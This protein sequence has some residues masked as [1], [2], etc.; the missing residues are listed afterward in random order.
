MSASDKLDIAILPSGAKHAAIV[1]ARC[2]CDMAIAMLPATQELKTLLAF[3]ERINTVLLLNQTRPTKVELTAFGRALFDYIVRD[4]VRRLYDRLPVDTLTRFQILVM[5]PELQALP[6]EYLQDPKHAPGPWTNRS[7]I[8]VIPMIGHTPPP[9]LQLTQLAATGSK[10]RILFVY[11]VP[12]DQDLVSWPSV[13]AKM[14]E[15]FSRRIPTEHYELKTIRGTTEELFAALEDN[16]ARYDI[17]Q[18]SG[19]GDVDPQTNEG[20]I[21]LVNSKKNDESLPLGASD[22]AILLEARGIRLA[23]LSACLTSAGNSADPFNVVAEALLT[24]GVPAVIANHL[25]IPDQS[26]ATFVGSLYKL[27]VDTGDIDR[28]VNAGRLRLAVELATGSDATLEWGIPTLY[29]HIDGA[30]VFQP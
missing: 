18:F 3:K 8:R 24:A 30:Q 29:R 21:L 2:G 10:I 16:N 4:D 25:P 6:W 28:A 20:R 13:K 14:E 22:L 5:I 19:H 9:P 1:L 23:V 27:L 12:Q 15:A 26:V 17:F 11:A 7:I